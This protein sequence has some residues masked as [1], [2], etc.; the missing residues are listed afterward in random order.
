MRDA[1]PRS[2]RIRHASPGRGVRR[3]TGGRRPD[4]RRERIRPR[5]GRPRAIKGLNP[6]GTLSH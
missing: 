1:R 2:G 3:R 6:G 4:G 5:E